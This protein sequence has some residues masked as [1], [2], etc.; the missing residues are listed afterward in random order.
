MHM[1]RCVLESGGVLQI[2][3]NMYLLLLNKT[4][5]L[6]ITPLPL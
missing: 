3:V 2:I 4:P 1:I 5:G 6:I